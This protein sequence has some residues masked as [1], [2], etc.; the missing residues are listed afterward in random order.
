MLNEADDFKNEEEM[1]P[2]VSNIFSF[3]FYTQNKQNFI[4]MDRNVLKPL[5][6]NS[7]D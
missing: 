1:L 7:E 6:L 5:A 4:T 2:Q 3:L